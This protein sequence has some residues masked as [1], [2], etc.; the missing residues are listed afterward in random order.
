MTDVD[1]LL[2]EA[3]G[4]IANAGRGNWGLEHEDW[5]GAAVQWREKY[6][7]YLDAKYGVTS[8]SGWLA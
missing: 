7:K 6:H 3:W 5:Q 1:D 2:Q 4:V 8:R